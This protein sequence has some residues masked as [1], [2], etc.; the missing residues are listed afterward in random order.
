MGTMS[1]LSEMELCYQSKLYEIQFIPPAEGGESFDF[2]IELELVKMSVCLSVISISSH[3]FEDRKLKIDRN[4]YHI[5]GT[6]SA[7]QVF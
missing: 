2:S 5:N 4:N 7:N 6:K 1:H 3:S